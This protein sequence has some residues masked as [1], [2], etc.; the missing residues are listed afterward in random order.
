MRDVEQTKQSTEGIRS[1]YIHIPFCRNICYYCDFNKVFLEGQPVDRY[2]DGLAKEIEWTLQDVPQ[3][4]A[5]LYIGG[6]TPSTLTLVQWRKLFADLEKYFQLLPDCEFTIEVNPEDVSRELAELFAAQ[7][8]NRISMGVQTFNEKLLK[9]IGRKHTAA[10]VY[11]AIEAFQT[12]G[13]TNISVDLINALPGETL[14]DYEE[15]LAEALALD[16]P[17]YSFYSLI[18]EERTLFSQWERRG[19]LVLPEEDLSADMYERTVAALEKAGRKRYEIS[20]FALPGKESKHN[21]VYWNNQEYFGFGAGASGNFAGCRTQNIGP[22]AHYLK[23]ISV[24]ELPYRT[25]HL[26]SR[27]EAIE[28]EMFLGLR[29][30][31][32]VSFAEFF[33]RFGE[34][35][36]EVYGPVIER[37]IDQ[38][39]LVK[40]ADR[41]HLTPQGFLL[42]NIVFAGFLQD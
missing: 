5:T 1:V 20:N 36:D 34:M 31:S 16:L 32:G 6:G 12:A 41:I 18:L 3:R 37:F 28:E 23:K 38:G 40:E 8:V 11:R 27:Q 33:T 29:K 17:H 26:E 19:K 15:T 30:A 4:L 22:V 2:L 10:D 13:I 35:L 21:L 25:H 9:K 39:L 42:G 7:R 24:G 14:A